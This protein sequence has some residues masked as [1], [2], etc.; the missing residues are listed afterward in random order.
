MLMDKRKSKM[1]YKRVKA[2]PLWS[3]LVAS[4]VCGTL[5]IYGLRTNNQKMITLRDAVFAADEQD[6]DIEAALKTLREHVYTHMNTDLVSGEHAIKPPIQLKYRYE[7]LV[8]AEKARV[9]EARS[10]VY[11]D[12]QNHCEARFPTGFSG[13]GRIPCIQEYVEEHQ[14]TEQAINQDLYMYDFIS[15]RWSPDLAGWSIIL[16]GFFAIAFVVRLIS[17]QL[18]RNQLHGN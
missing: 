15:P 9:E 13:R 5:A 12:A 3:L 2:L 1:L 18:L 17:E 16:A 14:V 7:R 11:T 10:Q 8:A 4:L 6:G